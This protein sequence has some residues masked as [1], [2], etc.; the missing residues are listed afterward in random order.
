MRDESG[1]TSGSRSRIGE[2]EGKCVF[3]RLGVGC[4]W[5]GVTFNYFVMDDDDDDDDG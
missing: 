2:G 4:V 5:G 3:F 1:G